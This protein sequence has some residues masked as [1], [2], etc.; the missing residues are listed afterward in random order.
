MNAIADRLKP[1]DALVLVDVQKD[2]CPGGALAIENGDAVVPVLNQWIAAARARGVP[3]FASRCWHP[4]GHISFA[5]RGGPWPAHCLQ[6]SD[7]AAFHPDLQL[8]EDAVLVTKGNRFDQ[9][10]NSVFDQTGFAEELR[11]RGVQ[12][13]WVGGLA[14]D[15]CV[16][17]TVLDGCKAGFKVRVIGDATRPVTPE[18][19]AAARTEMTEAGA[20][21]LEASA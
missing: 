17:A 6:D 12:R 10:Q 15:V 16:R 19:G 3:V 18:G 2:F 7:G 9:D 20:E 1:G 5:E 21:L 14:E 8:P 11:T 4:M 13:V